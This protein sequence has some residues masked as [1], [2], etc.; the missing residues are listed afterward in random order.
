MAV[1][2]FLQEA[3]LNKELG[4]ECRS[5]FEKWVENSFIGVGN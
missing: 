5:Y 3:D 2:F 1:V 4:S